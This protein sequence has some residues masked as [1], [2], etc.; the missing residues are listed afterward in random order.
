VREPDPPEPIPTFPPTPIVLPYILQPGSPVA[1]PNFSHPELGC[2]WLGVGGQVFDRRGQPQKS[3]IIEIGGTLAGIEI[4]SIVVSGGAA[5][6][7][8]GGYEL[9]LSERPI[10]SDRTLWIQLFDISGEAVSEQIFFSTFNDCGQ[11]LILINFLEVPA[12]PYGIWL[13]MIE[14]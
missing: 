3:L 12:Q 14:R 13:P 5:I 2:K 7:G 11:N 4:K 10:G 6:F 8:E 9:T 1:V